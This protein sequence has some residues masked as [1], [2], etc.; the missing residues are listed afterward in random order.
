VTSGDFAHDSESQPAAFGAGAK[1]AIKAF[2]HAFA[3]GFRNAGAVVLN[4]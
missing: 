4:A 2:Q 3:L 1:H